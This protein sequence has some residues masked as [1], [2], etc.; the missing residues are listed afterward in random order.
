MNKSENGSIMIAALLMAMVIGGVV[1]LF[2][3]TVTKEVEYAHHSRMMLQL[4][5]HAEAG[6]D[7]AVAALNNDELS[8]GGWTGQNDGYYRDTANDDKWVFG[9]NFNTVN[10]TYWY[11]YQKRHV[12]VYIKSHQQSPK[13]VAEASITL[14]DGTTLDRQIYVELGTRSAWANG[15]LAKLSITFAG[16]NI[17][18]D[19]YNSNNGL[20]DATLNMNSNG[21]V[22]TPNTLLD[23]ISVGNGDVYGTVSVGAGEQEDGDIPIVV[24][25]GGTIAS[26]EQGEGY[27]DP[28]RISYDFTAD[29]P[30][31]TWPT[32]TSAETEIVGQTLGSL[33]GSVTYY[34]LNELNIKSNEVYTVQGDVVLIVEKDVNGAGGDID[35][36]GTLLLQPNT[37]YTEGNE[38][39]YTSL[40]VYVEGDFTM[41]GND[42]SSFNDLGRPQD[43]IVFGMG[44]ADP[45]TGKLPQISLGGNPDY[46]AAVYAPN[47]NVDLGGGGNSGQFF[48]SIVGETITLNGHY[49]FCYDEAL[50]GY[51]SGLGW[52]VL[53]WQELTDPTEKK[54]MAT[55]L[56]DGL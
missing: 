32:V 46:Y 2:L 56:T 9:Y 24:K 28:D 26:Y 19:S 8:A 31:P 1:G 11:R 53:W 4:I 20:Y 36:D 23:A 41:S 40:E 33:D 27:I 35:I 45:L 10:N 43:V 42:Y 3:K 15:L 18:I 50:A 25:R 5:S 52:K 17:L 37:N 7:T 14:P 22:A 38:E 21:S 39:Y 48:G 47:Y 44:T 55:I 30:D 6:I 51:D 12:K 54:N 29:L 16:N 34:R 13:I 49:H